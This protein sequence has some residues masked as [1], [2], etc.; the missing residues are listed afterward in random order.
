MQ[1]T[2]EQCLLVQPG[3]AELRGAPTRL[4]FPGVVQQIPGK[5]DCPPW[6]HD[7][8]GGV[9]VTWPVSF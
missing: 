8:S 2:P 4:S 1:E 5:G 6:E 7:R 9:G 3:G